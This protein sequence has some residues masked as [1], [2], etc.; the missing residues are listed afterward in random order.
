VVS[1]VTMPPWQCWRIADHRNR[2]R[3]AAQPSK[4]PHDP[5]LDGSFRSTGA[6]TSGGE[7]NF[8]AR[9]DLLMLLFARR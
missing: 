1:G 6:K 9:H 8:P 4:R 5:A 7:G 2:G 3:F